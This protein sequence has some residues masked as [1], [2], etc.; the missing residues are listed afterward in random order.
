M[1]F[2]C[3]FRPREGGVSTMRRAARIPPKTGH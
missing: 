2:S 3:S 1:L